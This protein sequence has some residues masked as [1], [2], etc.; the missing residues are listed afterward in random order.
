MANIWTASVSR[1]TTTGSTVPHTQLLDRKICID[2]AAEF[3]QMNCIQWI[4]H[5]KTVK[6]LKKCRPKFE[7]R[8]WIERER[9]TCMVNFS[10]NS[11]P[12]RVV[13][14]GGGG[15]EL[16]SYPIKQDGSPAKSGFLV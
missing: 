15:V 13:G 8:G 4:T 9:D 3:K 2:A 5:K 1:S 7:S 12:F 14:G 6:R 10:R 11:I 16:F